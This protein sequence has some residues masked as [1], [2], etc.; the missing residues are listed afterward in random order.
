MYGMSKAV[1]VFPESKYFIWLEDDVLLH[2]NFNNIFLNKPNPFTW[3]SNGHG[4]TCLIFSKQELID[5]AIPIIKQKYLNDIPLDW[6]YDFF[7]ARTNFPIK[8]AFH[9]GTISSR[10]DMVI[11]EEQDQEEYDR[12]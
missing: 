2:P 12:L 11:R 7:S 8:F 6:M 5:M 10:K 4:A 1:E 3:C 9:I